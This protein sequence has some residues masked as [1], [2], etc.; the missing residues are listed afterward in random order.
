MNIAVCKNMRLYKPAGK[1]DDQQQYKAI[2]E[3]AIV[4]TPDG[5]TDNS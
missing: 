3:S 4:S 1:F 5:F 2:I